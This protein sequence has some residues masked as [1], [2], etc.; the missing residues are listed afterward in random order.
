MSK[1]S[2]IKEDQW[3]KEDA[4]ERHPILPLL[5]VISRPK[6]YCLVLKLSMLVWPTNVRVALVLPSSERAQNKSYSNSYNF[7]FQYFILA[8]FSLVHSDITHQEDWYSSPKTF[9]IYQSPLTFY[10]DC[11][12]AS[13][14]DRSI[15]WQDQAFYSA[16]NSF[17]PSYEEDIR[18]VRG[19][20]VETPL[21]PN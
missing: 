4:L 2:K 6:T 11:L 14:I 20:L 17:G 18:E 15:C 12:L 19:S 16:S 5:R 3:R 13:F 10:D 8:P 7:H 9:A 1:M 21:E